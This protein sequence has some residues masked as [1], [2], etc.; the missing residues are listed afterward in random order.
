M[1]VALLTTDNREHHR[2]YDLTEPYFGPAIESILQGL[3]TL[4]ELEVHV[5]ACTQQPMVSP[6]KLAANTWFHLLDVSKVGWLRTGYQGCVRAIRRK[7]RELNPD[8]VHGEGTERECA[9]SAVLSGFPNLV[10]IHGNMTEL[11]RLFRPSVG[12]YLWSAAI[13][14]RFA[15]SRAGGVLC[16]SSYTESI[17]RRRCPRTWRVPNALRASFFEALPARSAAT[18]KPKL[19]NVGV[20]GA[21][22]R[23]LELLRSAEELHHAGHQ[24]EYFFIGAADTRDEYVRRFL[25]EV[26]Q[27]EQSGFARFLGEKSVTE[28][29][30]LMDSAS[31]LVHVPSEEAFGLVVAEALAR[32]LKV[33]G[34]EVGGLKDITAGVEGA[35]LFPLPDTDRFNESIARWLNAGSPRPQTAAQEMGRRYHPKVIARRH[36]EIYSEVFSRP[37][38]SPIAK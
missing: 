21:R 4:E 27:A 19:L 15:L 7:L 23:Q 9:L 18:S 29:I 22:K 12:S 37:S 16:N 5:I 14:E 34:S 13:L 1:R 26:E 33:F 38:S 28:L 2:R 10:T 36:L 32:N 31:A 30:S 6:S 35:E 24:F 25:R 11:A 3:A 17:V 8:V 20:I